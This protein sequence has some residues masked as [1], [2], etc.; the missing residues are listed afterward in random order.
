MLVT[1]EK[2]VQK[3]NGFLICNVSI[4][5]ARMSVYFVYCFS[6]GSGGY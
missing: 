4:L 6:D 3:P 1:A 2:S 5:I